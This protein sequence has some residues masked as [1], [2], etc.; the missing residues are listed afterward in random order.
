M[1]SK[2]ISTI[3]YLILII[4]FL[5]IA[6]LHVKLL[7]LFIIFSILIF[8]IIKDILNKDSSLLISFISLVILIL[9][10]MA[11]IYQPFTVTGRL[12]EGEYLLF[13][14]TK[15][16]NMKKI[17]GKLTIVNNNGVDFVKFKDDNSFLIK[18]EYK[19]NIKINNLVVKIISKSEYLTGNYILYIK[20]NITNE[21]QEYP[22]ANNGNI[23]FNNGIKLEMLNIDDNFKGYG[24]AIQI[25]Y[26]F[27]QSKRNHKQW[28]YK[29]YKEFN[30][31][32]ASDD[33]LTVMYVGDESKNIYDVEISFV[34][35][36]EKLIFYLIILLN[37]IFL[38]LNLLKAKKD[39]N[40]N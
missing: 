2:I 23:K 19:K 22:I 21:N 36:Y 18:K 17:N 26:N 6:D 28:L 5:F 16:N 9:L 31:I 3:T 40:E 12:T 1:P 13:G 24:K 25:S 29:D 34:P 4:S 35:P 27:P 8:N 30:L 11:V 33:P 39:K 37:I 20:N 14:K 10:C 15:D 32:T 7:L 38:G